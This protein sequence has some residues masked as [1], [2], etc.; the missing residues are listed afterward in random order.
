MTSKIINL[1]YDNLIIYAS[2]NSNKL[3]SMGSYMKDKIHKKRGHFL[4]IILNCQDTIGAYF[5]EGKSL[6]RI[7][8]PLFKAMEFKHIGQIG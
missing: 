1:I 3:I 4:Q 2:P 6:P 5:F 8:L 7:M